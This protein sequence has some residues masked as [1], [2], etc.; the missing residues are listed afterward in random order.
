MTHEIL[1]YKHRQ[2]SLHATGTRKFVCSYKLSTLWTLHAASFCNSFQQGKLVVR[3]K[4]Y[5]TFILHAVSVYNMLYGFTYL[6]LIIN[7]FVLFV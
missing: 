4:E 5:E 6:S 7:G 2:S 3:Q 1:V